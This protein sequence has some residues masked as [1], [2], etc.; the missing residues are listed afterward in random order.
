M[1]ASW[2]LGQVKQNADSQFDDLHVGLAPV[3]AA[4][5]CVD[6]AHCIHLHHPLTAG[7]G[8]ASRNI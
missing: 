1:E 7:W 2:Y 4:D 5:Q 6:H 3:T 8:Q